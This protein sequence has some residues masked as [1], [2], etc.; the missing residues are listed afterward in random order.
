MK[1]IVT[2]TFI[3]VLGVGIGLLVSE[4]TSTRIKRLTGTE[5]VNQAEQMKEISSF[6]WTTYVGSSSQRAY[7]EYG[8]PAFIG[9]GVHTTVYWVPL[10]ELPKDISDQI[11]T[12]HLPWKRCDSK[13]DGKE[14]KAD[15]LDPPSSAQ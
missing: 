2:H 10:A 13:T 6:H 3:L 4:C 15:A 5:F 7:L 14:N 1:R 9:K 11:K 8:H 12:G